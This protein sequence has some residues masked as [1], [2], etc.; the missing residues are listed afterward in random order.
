MKLAKRRNSERK[1]YR[2]REAQE[3]DHYQRLAR[4]LLSKARGRRAPMDD[5]SGCDHEWRPEGQTLT[6]YIESC[7][8]CGKLRFG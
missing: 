2:L 5:G 4:R 8:K 1:Q 6:G 3:L 7:S